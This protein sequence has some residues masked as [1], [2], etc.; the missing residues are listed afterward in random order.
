MN[1]H[2]EARSLG[3]TATL[4]VDLAANWRAEATASYFQDRTRQSQFQPLGAGL[5]N[6]FN[7]KNSVGEIELKADGDLIEVPA[8][9]VKLAVGA[10]MRSERYSS[11]FETAVNLPT[12]QSGTRNVRSLFAELNAP[13]FTSRNR[14]PG[15]EQLI[16]TAAGRFEHYEKLGS[17]FDPK[18]GLL[19][20]PL[21]GL[22][23]RGSYGTSSGA[24]AFR[25][26]RSLQCL[27]VS[28][29]AALY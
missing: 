26:A 4:G 14:R 23:F 12:P 15:L 6:I 21:K 19:W 27:P 3:G 29:V 25:D 9:A 11:L 22:R 7:T 18:V 28:L 5:V 16:L 8:G 1:A 20:S 17:S 13:F 24:A 2:A 10:Q